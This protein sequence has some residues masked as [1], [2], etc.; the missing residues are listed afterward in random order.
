MLRPS[1]SVCRTLLVLV[2]FVV[3]TTRGFISIL[4]WMERSTCTAFQF[5][6]FAAKLQRIERILANRGVGSRTDVAS[7]IR[8]GKVSV[9][10]RIVRG[11]SEKFPVDIPIV[12]AGRVSTEVNFVLLIFFLNVCYHTSDLY[13]PPFSWQPLNLWACIALWEIL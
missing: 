11:S 6:M 1:P 3:S 5:R 13:R 10:G 8:Q 4:P 9:D 2:M 12:V 7:L